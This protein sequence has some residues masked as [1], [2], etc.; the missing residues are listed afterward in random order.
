M[1][2]RHLNP[3]M[4]EPKIERGMDVVAGQITPDLPE[5]AKAIRRPISLPG[6]GRR[7]TASG[8]IGSVS[9]HVPGRGQI[10]DG[11]VVGEGVL[12]AGPDQQQSASQGQAADQQGQGQALL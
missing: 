1:D 10:G 5:Y 7:P 9:P 3:E 12:G 2:T 8:D 4:Q 11:V 6:L